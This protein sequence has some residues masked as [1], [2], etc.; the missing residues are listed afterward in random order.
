MEI[1]ELDM[2]FRELHRLHRRAMEIRLN[3]TGVY[4]A[5]HQILMYL[6]DHPQSSQIQICGAVQDL[7]FRGSDIAK[8]LEKGGYLERVV[9]MED[10]RF[11]KVSL[12]EKGQQVVENSHEIFQKTIREMYQNL[13]ESEREQMMIFYE[14]LEENLKRI[15]QEEQEK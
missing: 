13:S 5:Q 15:C 7:V 8:K 4:R 10:N 1:M 3:K 11:H 2:K 12:T 14:K 6:S 9:D